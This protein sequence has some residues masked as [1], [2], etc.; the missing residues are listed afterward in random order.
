[1]LNENISELIKLTQSD[2]LNSNDDEILHIATH[3]NKTDINKNNIH[4]IL[5]L[6]ANLT[7]YQI[8]YDSNNIIF[9]LDNLIHIANLNK[10]FDDS[11]SSD[12]E[13]DEIDSFADGDIISLINI[14]CSKK[15]ND[16]EKAYKLINIF[17]I[18]KTSSY[19]PIFQLL[20]RLNDLSNIKRLYYQYIKKNKSILEYNIKIKELNH[21]SKLYNEKIKLMKKK[22]NEILNINEELSKINIK[23]NSAEKIS[24]ILLFD[25]NDFKEHIIYNEKILITIPNNI[26]KDIILLAINYNDDL[27]INDIILNINIPTNELI[28]ILNIYFSRKNYEYIYS[29]INDGICACCNNLL[30]CSII[31]NEDRENIMI[32]ID[33][34]IRS[35]SQRHDNKL[36]LNKIEKQL[37]INKW[38]EYLKLL[39]NNDFDIVIDGA[40]LGY[41][42]TKN[43]DINIKLIQSTINEIILKSN[44]KILLI[45]HQRHINKIKHLSFHENVTIYATPNNVNDDLFWLYASIYC[46]CFI[47]S[48]DQSRD[49]GYMVSYQVEIKKWISAYQIKMNNL[50]LI[51][52]NKQ[53]I[54]APGININDNVIHIILNM[55][56]NI[57]VHISD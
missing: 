3:I 32:R 8:I 26:I 18:H 41:I 29:N 34:K 56:K 46:K 9:D 57:C 15:Y 27:F 5:K 35:I 31:S 25:N 53:S 17:N 7:K 51:Y 43:N 6:I 13:L 19:I 10:L 44:K 11:I 47:L 24:S 33:D 52:T 28:S 37:I 49:H 4:C 23:N 38:D 55:N 21:Q 20:I 36:Y 40:N 1:M 54:I 16:F 30:Q 48:N 50:S 2:N 14:Y 42:N 22:I 45:I 39:E 12:S